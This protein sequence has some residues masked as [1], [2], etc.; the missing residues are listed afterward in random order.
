MRLIQTAS[1]RPPAARIFFD[2]ILLPITPEF[3]LTLRCRRFIVK[4]MPHCN[5]LL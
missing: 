1:S 4:V 3:V 5:N 2:T